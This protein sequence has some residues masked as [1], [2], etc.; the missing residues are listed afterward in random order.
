M[1]EDAAGAEQ[2]SG[3]G[4]RL[5]ALAIAT[6]EAARV[7]KE[8]WNPPFCGDIPLRIARDGSWH[9][10]GSP[11]NRPALVRLFAGILRREGAR[12]VLVTPVEKVGIE[13]EDAPF[14][15]TEMAWADATLSLRTNLDEWI[16]VDATHPLRF[17]HGPAAGLKP[18]VRI[19]DDL[20]ALFTRPLAT[21]LIE[22]SD[23]RLVDGTET[24][25]IASGAHFFAIGPAEG[26]DDDAR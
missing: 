10:G 19:R 23:T 13:V 18:Y 6:H 7:P 25:G 5:E 9:Y 21:E 16:D 17:E 20:W 24:F 15:V 11:I 4:A 12:F 1:A 3:G 22:R 2:M 8:A 26:S 14:V